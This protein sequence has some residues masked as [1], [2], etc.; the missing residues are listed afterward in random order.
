MLANS[1]RFKK[2]F[3]RE[4]T[5]AIHQSGG[6]GALRVGRI[7]QVDSTAGVCSIM[8]MDRP[9]MR[10]NVL[11]TQGSPKEWN[12]PERGAV[13]LVG[14]DIKDQARILRYIN[15]GHAS[16]IVVEKSLPPLKEGEKLWE[17]GSSYFY[18]RQ[19]GDII[20]STI[21]GMLTLEA[22]T[23]T[24]KGEVVNWRVIS[25]AGLEYSGLV[26]RFVSDSMNNKIQKIITDEAGN[27]YTE[28]KLKIIETA[29]A[30][31]GVTQ[32]NS[33][34]IDI[35][36]GT[37]VDSDG[38]VVDKLGNE[39]TAKTAGKVIN[40]KVALSNGVQLIIDKEGFITLSGGVLNVNR[41]SLDKVHKDVDA[42]LEVHVARLG[43]RGQHAA[44]EHDAIKIPLSALF[45]DTSHK[46]LETKAKSN[47]DVLRSIAK[48]FLSPQGPCTLN[49]AL[50]PSSIVLEGEII[51][52]AT[53]VYIGD[54]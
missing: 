51:E 45:T 26:K 9:G 1:L 6:R 15:V 31:V 49:D 37:E 46:T 44:R 27:A 34:L 47:V 35:T 17:A 5:D 12:I 40:V 23:G 16:K 7:T 3:L 14:F 19:N 4:V 11:L 50:L 30:E 43:E 48:A 20:L 32:L 18:L 41:A 25:E 36:L 22:S 21:Q 54:S 38:L 8:W 52:G 39:V 42:G 29:D 28:Y 24:L 33:P 2:T 10:E 53:N 13:V